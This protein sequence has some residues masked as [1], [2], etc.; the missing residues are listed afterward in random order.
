MPEPAFV[1]DNG[2]HDVSRDDPR[3]DSNSETDISL[4][5]EHS[6]GQNPR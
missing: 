2:Q 1:T 4:G 6:V 5:F 3:D